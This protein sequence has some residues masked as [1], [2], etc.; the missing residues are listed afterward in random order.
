LISASDEF[1]IR[2]C[3]FILQTLN[4]LDKEVNI[5]YNGYVSEERDNK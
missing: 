2:S 3:F 4:L 5:C 1:F